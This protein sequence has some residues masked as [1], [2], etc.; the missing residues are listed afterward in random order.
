MLCVLVCGSTRI[1]RG[2]TTHVVPCHLH[3]EQ[4]AICTHAELEP[5]PVA[6]VKLLPVRR[7][8][9]SRRADHHSSIQD[10]AVLL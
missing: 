10:N 8:W 2:L 4:R 9:Q 5:Q 3:L 1:D 7:A 6:V